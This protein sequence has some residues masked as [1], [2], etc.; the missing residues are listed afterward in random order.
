MESETEGQ[1][2][3]QKQMTVMLPE[4]RSCLSAVRRGAICVQ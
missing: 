1:I 3:A 2:E 4:P